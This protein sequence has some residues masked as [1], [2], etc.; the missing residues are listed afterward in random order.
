[1]LKPSWQPVNLLGSW[2]LMNPLLLFA[3]YIHELLCEST[4]WECKVF[5][6]NYRTKYETCEKACEM[7]IWKVKTCENDLYETD[8]L[9]RNM[10]WKYSSKAGLL[11]STFGKAQF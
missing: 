8:S 5:A 11:A 2:L 4:I 9:F 7:T 1:M 3:L 6:Q 10:A